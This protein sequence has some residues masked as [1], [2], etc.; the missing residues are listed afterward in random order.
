MVLKAMNTLKKEGSKE[1]KVAVASG[2]AISVVVVLLAAWAI[3][4]FRG[5][6]RGSHDLQIGGGA[7]DQ[8]N[9]TSV[10]D[11]HQALQQ[12]LANPSSATPAQSDTSGS[13]TGGAVQMQISGQNQTSPFGTTDTGN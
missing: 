3:F 12:D 4:F 1:D 9:F 8:F 5:I 11:A 6:A 7:Q 10:K 2:V 13:Q